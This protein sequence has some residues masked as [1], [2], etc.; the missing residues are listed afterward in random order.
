MVHMKALARGYVWWPGLDAD[1]EEWVRVCEPCQQ[2][3]PEPPTATPQR[4]ESVGKPWSRLHLDFAGPVQGQMFLVIVD[5]YTKWLEVAHMRSTT[6]S[7]VV[8]VLR[9]LFATHGLPDVFVSDNGAQFTSEEFRKFLSDNGIRQMTAAPFHPA[10][11]GQAER[12][13]RTIKEALAKLV[14]GDWGVKLAS[15]LLRQHVTPCSA[16]GRSPAEMLMGRRL[17][18]LLDRLHP[19]LNDLKPQQQCEQP[20]VQ[21]YE[22]G[23]QV[24]ARNYASG[25]SWLPATITDVIGTRMYV[26]PLLKRRGPFKTSP[27]FPRQDFTAPLEMGWEP[28]L[29]RSGRRG[30][31]AQ[32]SRCPS[33]DGAAS[34]VPQ[35]PA[36]LL[37]VYLTS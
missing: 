20:K 32:L 24:F 22:K 2:A 25:H 6:S 13:V 16:T 17:A 23:E 35:S 4:W 15:F 18:T 28:C 8:T 27:S 34:H 7:A 10:S 26:L 33:A 21:T 31:A 3:R 14:C 1:I 29:S 12:M 9:Q 5:A 37:S 30:E 36:V 11:N 19:D